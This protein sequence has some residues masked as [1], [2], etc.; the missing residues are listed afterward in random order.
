MSR[1]KLRVVSQG[2]FAGWLEDTMKKEGLTVSGVSSALGVTPKSV[3]D[4]RRGKGPLH[5]NHVKAQLL[6]NIN[7]SRSREAKSREKLIR[8]Q[9]HSV[10]VLLDLFLP[11][12]V[13]HR[14]A[15]LPA[16]YRERYRGRVKDI[17]MRVRRELDEY[18]KVL[19]GE[20]RAAEEKKE[21]KTEPS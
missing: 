4:W 17:T 6:Q 16:E 1:K 12:D 13:A 19:E 11:E 14:L 10:R 15:H 18:L 8:D 7:E 20:C 5:P 9:K 21:N 3:Y 2:E